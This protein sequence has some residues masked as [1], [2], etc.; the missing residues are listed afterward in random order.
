MDS[1]AIFRQ[2]AEQCRR[3][4]RA[5][6]VRKDPTV[7]SLEALAVEFEAKALRCSREADEPKNN[8]RRR[9]EDHQREPSATMS[10]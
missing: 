7:T 6:S 2:R 3:L 5:L 10:R 1:A 4:A 8:G 9:T